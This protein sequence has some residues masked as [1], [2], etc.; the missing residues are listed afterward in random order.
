MAVLGRDA[1]PD[2]MLYGITLAQAQLLVFP[3]DVES[4]FC[5]TRGLVVPGMEVAVPKG[6][7]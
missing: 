6:S 5:R 4:G 7:S 3:W 1:A 2:A